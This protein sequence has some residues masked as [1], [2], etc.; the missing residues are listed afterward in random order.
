M[1]KTFLIFLPFIVLDTAASLSRAYAYS[2]SDCKADYQKIAEEAQ[3]KLDSLVLQD[4]ETKQIILEHQQRRLDT[5]AKLC[6]SLKKEE[7]ALDSEIRGAKQ[8]KKYGPVLRC[9]QLGQ[10]W[11]EFQNCSQSLGIEAT[12]HV[13]KNGIELRAGKVGEEKDHRELVTASL[14][15]NH[16]VKSISIHHPKFFGAST[17][18]ETFLRAFMHKHEIPHLEERNVPNPFFPS[19]P[20]ERYVYST[21]GWGITNEKKEKYVSRRDDSSNYKF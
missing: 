1:K 9:Y 20:M 12:L 17:F 13:F 3:K 21:D 8:G 5:Q 19:L 18:N 6:K 14:D 15:A 11:S 4:K 16:Y 10:N 2:Y 7:I